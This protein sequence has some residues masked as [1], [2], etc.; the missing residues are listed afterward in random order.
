MM[1]NNFAYVAAGFLFGGIVA[2]SLWLVTYLA[3]LKFIELR[4]GYR[5]AERREQLEAAW[6]E[7]LSNPPQIRARF[8]LHTRSGHTRDELLTAR[9]NGGSLTRFSTA[10]PNRNLPAIARNTSPCVSRW[11]NRSGCNSPHRPASRTSRNRR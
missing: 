8:Q 5:M 10:F 11:K 6:R 9:N 1:F 4:R 3:R 2:G 7:Q